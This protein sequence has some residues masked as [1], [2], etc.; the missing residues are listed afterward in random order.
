MRDGDIRQDRLL[1]LLSS[2][3]GALGTGLA[4]VGIYG[5]IAYPV[6]R[7]TRKVGIRVSGGAQC[8]DGCGFSCASRSCCWRAGVAIGLPLATLLARLAK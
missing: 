1:A 5:L 3:F 4:L 7:R 6:T 8:G 2:I